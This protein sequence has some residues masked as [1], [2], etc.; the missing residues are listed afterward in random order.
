MGL[1]ETLRPHQEGVPVV[2]NNSQSAPRESRERSWGGVKFFRGTRLPDRP[3]VVEGYRTISAEN[4]RGA[5]YLDRRVWRPEETLEAAKPF[6]ELG[7]VNIV[8]APQSGKGTILYGLS[9]ICHRLGW[10]Y[11]F[12]DGHHQETTPEFVVSTIAEAQRRRI[13]IFFD[14]FDYLFAKGKKREISL[15]KQRGHTIVENGRRIVIPGRTEA[16]IKALA[17]VTVPVAITHHDEVWLRELTD[18]DFRNQFSRYL[19]AYPVY[20]IPLNFYSDESIVRFLE[21]QGIS[22]TRA[23]FMVKMQQNKVVRDILTRHFGDKKTVDAVFEALKNYPVLKELTRGRKGEL[24]EQGKQKE[25]SAE[26]FLPLLSRVTNAFSHNP[27][28]VSD[29]IGKSIADMG[30]IILEA[31]YKRIFLS[32]LRRV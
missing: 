28:H 15:A 14:S 31:E 12:V 3:N 26:S 7:R 11:L 29:S 16:I 10:G 18:V 24:D 5:R 27:N 22:P 23:A 19:D 2:L 20:E 6:F 8:G 30:K 32:L 9:E 17:E 1:N 13:P 21:D 4:L 25:G